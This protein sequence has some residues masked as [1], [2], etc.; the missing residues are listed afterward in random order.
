[1]MQQA[2]IVATEHFLWAKEDGQTN[3][4]IVRSIGV[5]AYKGLSDRQV[6][7]EL[8]RSWLAMH[9]GWKREPQRRA[10]E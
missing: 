2:F 6:I 3:T 4:Q 8:Q 10:A 9:S 1:M 5:P 7:Q